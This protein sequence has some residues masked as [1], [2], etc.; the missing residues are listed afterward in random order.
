MKKIIFHRNN[1]FMFVYCVTLLNIN[2]LPKRKC[3]ACTNRKKLELEKAY[4]RNK[5]IPSILNTREKTNCVRHWKYEQ[6]VLLQAKKHNINVVS[7]F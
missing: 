2:I 5:N 4:K 3:D 1:I 7:I 6:I